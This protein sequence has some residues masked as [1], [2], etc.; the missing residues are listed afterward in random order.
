MAG[1]P[2]VNPPWVAVHLEHAFRRDPPFALDSVDLPMPGIRP[3]HS[4]LGQ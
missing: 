1:V 3:V 4:L 2:L